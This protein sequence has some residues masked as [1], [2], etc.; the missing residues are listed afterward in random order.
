MSPDALSMKQRAASRAGAAPEFPTSGRISTRSAIVPSPAM[1][2]VLADDTRPG[3]LRRCME[4][5]V[6]AVA[7]PASTERVAC[8]VMSIVH[9]SDEFL[10]PTARA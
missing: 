3:A 10:D 4:S 5:R 7:G 9:L 1:Y 6:T 8:V 2:S